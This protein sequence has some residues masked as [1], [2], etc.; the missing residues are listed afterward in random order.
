MD[1]DPV[2]ASN[3][4]NWLLALSALPADVMMI[5]YLN[6]INGEAKSNLL[7]MFVAILL[8]SLLNAGYYSLRFFDI[9]KPYPYANG[10]SIIVNFVLTALAWSFVFLVRKI[11]DKK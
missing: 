9:I 5:R 3:I 1:Y 8:A 2:N 7:F 11:N 4:L 6:K 10:R